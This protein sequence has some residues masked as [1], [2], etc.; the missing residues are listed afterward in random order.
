MQHRDP[1]VSGIESGACCGPVLSAL[2]GGWHLLSS[3][4]QRSHNVP[5]KDDT[6][7]LDLFMRSTL[8]R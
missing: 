2:L 5:H 1:R 7:L 4:L 3:W 8:G 6:T